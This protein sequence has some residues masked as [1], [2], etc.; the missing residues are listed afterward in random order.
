[1]KDSIEID[2]IRYVREQPAD[3]TKYVI[4]RTQWAGVFAGELVSRNGSEAEMR[5]ARCLWSWK[6]ANSASELALYGVT[7]PK[8]C[9]F[10]APVSVTLL[11]V[12][13]VYPCSE[14][15]RESIQGVPEW[16]TQ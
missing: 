1:M 15:A 4:V 7:A 11:G 13:A 12:I 8:E 2:G 9:R 5:H 10:A 3:N 14:K 6:G 16:K